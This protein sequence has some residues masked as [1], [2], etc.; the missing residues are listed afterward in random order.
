MLEFRGSIY[1]YSFC[2]SLNSRK[3]EVPQLYTEQLF[4]KKYQKTEFCGLFSWAI[5]TDYLWA[6]TVKLLLKLLILRKTAIQCIQYLHFKTQLLHT[7]H[8]TSSAVVKIPLFSFLS[9][10][11]IFCSM[12]ISGHSI[13]MLMWGTLPKKIGFYSINGK[14]DMKTSWH[15]SFYSAQQNVSD[16]KPCLN[17]IEILLGYSP[18]KNR[19]INQVFY[20]SLTSNSNFTIIYISCAFK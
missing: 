6:P 2:F 13:W 20:K 17:G 8:N 14:Q 10:L 7:W 5:P 3:A 16:K 18:E 9:R 19:T 15:S 11:S 12:Q 1:V 4:L